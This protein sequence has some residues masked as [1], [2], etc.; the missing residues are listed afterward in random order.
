MAVSGVVAFERFF[1]EAASLD[2]DKQDIK[3]FEDFIDRVL[4]DLLVV[5]QETASANGRDV[6][7]PRDLPI[8]R[9]LRESIRRF[10]RMDSEI[11]LERILERL[12]KRPQLDA[13]ISQET[14]ARLPLIAGGIGV[15]LAQTFRIV[16]PNVRNPATAQWERAQ[17]IFDLLI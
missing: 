1:R 17:R 8:T 11:E 12:A 9:G 7:E 13:V 6:I 3:R 10:E 5:G 16:D 2:V 4:Y 15:A 14:E